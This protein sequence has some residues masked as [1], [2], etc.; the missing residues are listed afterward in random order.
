LAGG[1]LALRLRI[2]PGT[3]PNP[4]SWLGIADVPDGQYRLEH[5]LLATDDD[6]EVSPQPATVALPA[7]NGFEQK[8][9]DVTLKQQDRQ[10]IEAELKLFQDRVGQRVTVKPVIYHNPKTRQDEPA[11]EVFLEGSRDP[12]CWISRAH[13]G[14]VTRELT[15]ILVS[16]GKYSLTAVCTLPQ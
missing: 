9:K 7:V 6:S 13:V 8:L 4:A 14:A 16:N 1:I 12:L 11:A 3:T 10:R 15:G 5:G 2:H